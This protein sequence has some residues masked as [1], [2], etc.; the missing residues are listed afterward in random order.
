MFILDVNE[1]ANETQSQL[2]FFQTAPWLLFYEGGR[3][4]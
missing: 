1:Y 2:L 3:G 4:D